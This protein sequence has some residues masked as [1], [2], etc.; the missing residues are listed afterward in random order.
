MEL[1]ILKMKNNYTLF[2]L[3]Y[4]PW[5]FMIERA[6]GGDIVNNAHSVTI[7]RP[8]QNLDQKKMDRILST[9]MYYAMSAESL[10]ST[11]KTIHR[12]TADVSYSPLYSSPARVI[13]S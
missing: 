10:L 5:A 11:L 8:S 2:H 12:P 3:P 1:S 9:R 4:V 13:K 7:R 6:R